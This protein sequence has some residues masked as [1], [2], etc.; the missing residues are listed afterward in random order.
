MKIVNAEQALELDI[1]TV[2]LNPEFK[3]IDI[4]GQYCATV[5]TARA[6]PSFSALLAPMI[7]LSNGM[8]KEFNPKI[9][10]LSTKFGCEGARYNISMPFG[11]IDLGGRETECRIA[12][13]GSF[14]S[15]SSDKFGLEMKVQICSNGMMGWRANEQTKV[16]TRFSSN[17]KAI[18]QDRIRVM[19]LGFERMQSH[20]IQLADQLAQTKLSRR[21]VDA[22]LEKLYGKDSKQSERIREQVSTLF[23]SGKGN[24]G[25]SAWDLFNAVTEYENHHKTYK[26]TS[27][28]SEEN[29]RKGVL[30]IDFDSLAELVA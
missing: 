7:D 14:N 1:Q 28:G 8:Q 29:R 24:R 4:D 25:E 21:Q 16:I 22:R 9:E 26:N 3:Q 11:T 6:V 13:S 19:V 17:W 12:R 18:S 20:Y 10:L 30:A 27:V 15:S 23:V 2:Q 5:G